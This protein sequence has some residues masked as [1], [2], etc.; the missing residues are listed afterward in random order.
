VARLEMHNFAARPILPEMRADGKSADTVS[1]R[2][3]SL[4]FGAC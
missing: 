2:A 1:R 3:G 4:S